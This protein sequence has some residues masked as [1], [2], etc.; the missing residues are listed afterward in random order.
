LV[1]VPIV[2]VEGSV[3]S[4]NS[5]FF[6]FV[7]DAGE[8]R[9]AHQV[10]KGKSYSVVVTTGGGFY[11]YQLH[12][13]VEVIGHW[14]QI[15]CIR[16]VGKVDS[17]SDWF[18]EKLEEHFVARVLEKIFAEH[19]ISPVFAMLAPDDSANFRYCLYLECDHYNDQLAEDLDN[20][21]RKNFH[22]DYCRKLG[23]LAPVQVVS[24]SHGVEKYVRACQ[25]RGQKLGNIK[26]SML[27]KHLGWG[28]WFEIEK[29]LA[30]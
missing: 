4:I 21:L 23:Q 12:D 8:V 30:I 20:A 19:K 1:S 18:G 26:P 9:L 28:K 24:V 2:G 3:L 17:I 22:Y 29:E 15:P 6:E 10:E 5:H 13:V 16:F 7:D 27:Q 11:R 14:G 25:A